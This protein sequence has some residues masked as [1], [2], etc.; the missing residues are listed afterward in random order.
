MALHTALRSPH[1]LGGVIA[2]SAW[3]PFKAEYPKKV[4]C[5]IISISS[6]SLK[7]TQFLFDLQLS[8]AAAHLAVLQIHG[9]ADQ[10]ISYEWGIASHVSLGLSFFFIVC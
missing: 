5:L 9:K 3:L 7:F 1:Q 10:V 2:L 8:A 6:S 4:V